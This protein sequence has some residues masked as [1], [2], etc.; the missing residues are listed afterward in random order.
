ML[1]TAVTLI[2]PSSNTSIS[3][4]SR[5]AAAHH[6][7][8]QQQ[9]SSESSLHVSTKSSSHHGGIAS[10]PVLDGV[11]PRYGATGW[12]S[13]TNR[14]LLYVFGGCD[15]SGSPTA[16]LQRCNVVSTEVKLMSFQ[17]GPSARY[18]HA[19][20]TVH[21][22]GNTFTYGGSGTAMLL[23]D[24]WM[25][26]ASEFTWKEH[27]SLGNGPGKRH[28]HQIGCSG[29]GTALV[30]VGGS[31]VPPSLAYQHD[32]GNDGA[33]ERDDAARELQ[34]Q[35]GP[36][37]GTFGK[38]STTKD[39]VSGHNEGGGV[40]VY[41][42][43][44][45][46]W[47]PVDVSPQ[48][49]GRRL[50]SMVAIGHRGGHHATN[51][52][53]Q[54][55][56]GSHHNNSIA[57]PRGGRHASTVVVQGGGMFSGGRAPSIANSAA[58]SSSKASPAPV[59]DTFL[60]SP[61]TR[62]T[63][64]PVVLRFIGGTRITETHLPA[65]VDPSKEFSFSPPSHPSNS[66]SST[67]MLSTSSIANPEQAQF[68][69]AIQP[70][71]TRRAGSIFVP[72]S[73]VDDEPGSVV[74]QLSREM[75]AGF[76]ANGS[77]V[78]NSGATAGG[79][80]AT[81]D[82]NESS[83]SSVNAPPYSAL[84]E[85]VVVRL[86]GTHEGDL[87]A[88]TRG[89]SGGVGVN[90]VSVQE[91][92]LT[93]PSAAQVSAGSSRVQHVGVARSVVIPRCVDKERTCLDE[94]VEAYVESMAAQSDDDNDDPEG[95]LTRPQGDRRGTVINRS[96]SFATTSG[97][98][99]VPLQPPLIPQRVLGNEWLPPRPLDAAVFPPAPV[100][101]SAGGPDASSEALMTHLCH[102]ANATV[103]NTAGSVFVFGGK[104][105]L[106]GRVSGAL[107]LIQKKPL[108]SEVREH[109]MTTRQPRAGG[110]SSPMAASTPLSPHR[111][112]S[113]RLQTILATMGSMRRRSFLSTDKKK[114]KGLPEDCKESVLQR[115]QRRAQ[116]QAVAERRAL[117]KELVQT[118]LS[119]GDI[120]TPQ[121]AAATE[122]ALLERMESTGDGALAW[123]LHD[124]YHVLVEDLLK[125]IGMGSPIVGD[126]GVVA[127]ETAFYLRQSV[128]KHNSNGSKRQHNDDVAGDGDGGGGGRRHSPLQ[129]QNGKGGGRGV[130]HRLEDDA[131]ISTSGRRYH[132][133]FHPPI[134]SRSEA[135]AL[136]KLAQPSTKSTSS[137]RPG[138]AK[139]RNHASSHGLVSAPLSS[140][141]TA[142]R[143]QIR[144]ALNREE[145]Q[146]TTVH[147]AR[148]P[149]RATPAFSPQGGTPAT[150]FAQRYVSA[151][152]RMTVNAAIRRPRSASIQK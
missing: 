116:D 110:P 100:P 8:T 126:E 135:V 119:S 152:A 24:L 139:G 10:L 81:G 47:I 82:V 132:E 3:S 77:G 79:P 137:V 15:A 67:T 9:Q 121:Q 46:I 5:N 131:A 18:L 37:H 63:D 51:L 6:H 34:K 120:K 38:E 49:R 151:E 65:S 4:P 106:D 150:I 17:K 59:M 91:G 58:A 21:S 140:D 56:G 97:V 41:K 50:F 127:S 74:D 39:G 147:S 122:A 92:R 145:L 146:A 123:D 40:W 115:C 96:S 93:L 118:L 142:H 61:G 45:E 133:W 85:V 36:R 99:E 109:S 104:S 136:E 57:S 2:E 27:R 68:A 14:E 114:P 12:A 105:E 130:P 1:P 84:D 101:P 73:P 113:M 20:A 86:G 62:S 55:Q 29:C 128:A 80:S 87:A 22:T 83:S 26:S 78:N 108:I 53:V 144:V 54:Q 31:V 60:C 102:L 89:I 98:V 90:T 43:Q 48:L 30:V 149:P 95:G 72:Y 117:A 75:L 44:S 52:A 148:P 103:I 28:S 33:K 134:V 124:H 125:P 141:V 112:A 16:T 19:T 94:L 23:D 69:D 11:Y 129:Q 143:R 32:A 35:L 88:L 7:R 107:F 42:L 64:V 111:R 70:P 66:S 76:F 13:H 71:P 138:S 25:W